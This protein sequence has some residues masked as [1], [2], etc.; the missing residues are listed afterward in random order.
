MHIETQI[1]SHAQAHR[2]PGTTSIVVSVLGML[3]D[4]YMEVTSWIPEGASLYGAGEF[5]PSQ[6]FQLKRDGTPIALWNQD[7]QAKAPDVNLY[8]ARPFL[9]SVLPG[10]P[11]LQ[12]C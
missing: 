11:S 12:P 9:L 8:G 2:A 3:Q 5:T 6:G 4:Q 7:Q 1:A 10:W